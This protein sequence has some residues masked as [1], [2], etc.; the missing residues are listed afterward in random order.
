MAASTVPT[1]SWQ[2]YLNVTTNDS[3]FL[4]KGHFK[5]RTA[6]ISFIGAGGEWLILRSLGLK[7][8]DGTYV[9]KCVRF[10][11]R[12]AK[13]RVSETQCD[14]GIEIQ[15]NERYMACINDLLEAKKNTTINYEGNVRFSSENK[16]NSHCCSMGPVIEN[17][18]NI[19]DRYSVL[20]NEIGEENRDLLKNIAVVLN[21][22]IGFQNGHVIHRVSE[23][24][25]PQREWLDPYCYIQSR[26]KYREEDHYLLASV[27]KKQHC[28]KKL[29]AEE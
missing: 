14:F 2:T 23:S 20:F 16:I 11:Y 28:L 10:H 15:H 7:N 3:W 22:D 6:E 25:P 21:N 9:W 5:R 1:I 27:G 13:A 24:C 17:F 18:L 4:V 8:Y 26:M 29:H 12:T 19:T